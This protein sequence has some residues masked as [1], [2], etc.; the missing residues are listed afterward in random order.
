MLRLFYQGKSGE[1]SRI[2]LFPKSLRNH[3]SLRES[4]G[5]LFLKGFVDKDFSELSPLF[6][7]CFLFPSPWFL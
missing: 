7:P 1:T 6:P 5:R 2:C 3:M 4:W